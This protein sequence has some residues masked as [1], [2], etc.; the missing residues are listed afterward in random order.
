M[1]DIKDAFVLLFAANLIA[2]TGAL[3]QAY[4]PQTTV[5]L[6]IT[7]NV[8]AASL[9]AAALTGLVMSIVS[10]IVGVKGVLATRKAVT[11]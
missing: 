10:L 3:I 2:V 9:F 4:V 5:A 6:T 1:N 7:V 11:A 8:Y